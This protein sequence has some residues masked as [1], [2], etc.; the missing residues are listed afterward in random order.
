MNAGLTGKQK[1]FLR[2]RGHHIKPLVHIGK[3]GLAPVLIEQVEQCLLAYELIK[4]K[5]LESSPMTK[6]EC[7]HA[8]SMATGALLAQT[9]GHT[10]LVYRPHPEKPVLQLPPAL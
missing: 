9:V 8:I 10:L 7:A 6:V 2:G 1:R 4:V 3:L 5:V